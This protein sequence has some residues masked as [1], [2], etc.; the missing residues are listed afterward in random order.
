MENKN[1]DPKTGMTGDTGSGSTSTGPSHGAGPGG[2]S[3]PAAGAK[4]AATATAATTPQTDRMVV[5]TA[6]RGVSCVRR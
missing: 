5:R 4:L 6:R 2:A 1:N 3:A